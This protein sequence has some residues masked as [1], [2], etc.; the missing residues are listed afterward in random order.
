[1][2]FM[3]LAQ[4]VVDE[5]FPSARAAI[6]AGSVA[7]GRAN[8]FSDLDI[9]VVLDG[10]PAPYRETLRVEGWPVEPF[11][12]TDESIAYWFDVERVKGGCTLAHMLATGVVL[13]G[14]D[15]GTVQ[16][17]AR[18]HVAE[19]PPVWTAD[20]FEYRRY[21]LSD[22][23]DD[24]SGAREDNERD[25]VAGHVLVSAAELRLALARHW[26]GTGNWLYRRLR[27]CDEE[28][29]ERMYTGHRLLVAGGDPRGF[30]GA[31]DDVLVPLGGRLI[32]GFAVREPTLRSR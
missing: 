27:E 17:L 31:V 11:V 7:Q 32:E 10:P 21:L 12:H 28:L 15:A 20:A 29:A 3:A 26:Q 5:G 8:A 24:L 25:A 2:D 6:L 16:E 4:G 19:G 22:A 23:L 1:M 18:A 13:A 9:V 14:P 30:V